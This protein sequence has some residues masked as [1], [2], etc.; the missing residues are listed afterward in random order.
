M[1]PSSEQNDPIQRSGDS[2]SP[3]PQF[4]P[5]CLETFCFLFRRELEP[6]FLSKDYHV[7]LTLAMYIDRTH[8]I[9]DA[10]DFLLE[11][12]GASHRY[13]SQ[14]L[15]L[16]EGDDLTKRFR[17]VLGCF[18]TDP[19]MSCQL[20]INADIVSFTALRC[21]QVIQSASIKF[22]KCFSSFS[23]NLMILSRHYRLTTPNLQ[24]QA[25]QLRLDYIADIKFCIS[26]LMGLLPN[27]PATPEL[28]TA[29]ERFDLSSNIRSRLGNRVRRCDSIMWSY[30]QVSHNSNPC[31]LIYSNDCH[32]E[33]SRERH[34][35][36]CP[37]LTIDN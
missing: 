23:V 31:I 15:R 3:C 32:S 20:V 21:L 13:T 25:L 4:W 28:V 27:A 10:S 5:R 19:K 12:F 33:T 26:G 6:H 8:S 1:L 30:L 24:S 2:P 29:V 36:Q 9:R 35:Y 14:H 22:E 34:L 16:F 37:K 18:L 17:Y 11:S 7:S